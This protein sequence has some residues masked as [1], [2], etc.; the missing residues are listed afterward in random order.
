[1]RKVLITGSSGLVGSASARLFA[2]EEYAVTGIDNGMRRVFFGEE[3]ATDR[4]GAALKEELKDR[5]VQYAA[6]IRD[7]GAIE[8]VF[9][10]RG[11]F[12]VVIHAAAQ[13]S[14]DWAARDP[15]L[16]FDVNARATL[17]LL[18]TCRR[19]SPETVFIFVSTNKVYGDSMNALPFVEGDTRYDLSDAHPNF[20]GI[21]EGFGI[22][23]TLH[24]FLG[25][26][27]ASADL[28]VQEYGSTIGLMT[29]VFRA[30]CITG[31]AHQGAELHGFLAYLVKCIATGRMY[32][33][34]GYQGKQVRDQLHAHDVARMFLLFSQKPRRGEVYNVG[35]SRFANASVLESIRLAEAIL[36]KHALTEYV[37]E[38]RLGDHTWYISDISKFRSH[39]PDWDYT[40]TLEGILR[41]LCAVHSQ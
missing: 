22:D 1:M 5:F 39:Y 21:D 17:A 34:F 30:G 23:Q 36:G 38:P 24:T 11:P 27:K 37:S 35:G 28:I 12:D 7:T 3:A 31:A 15:L 10:E 6:D 13:P 2:G 9:E 4:I 20:K 41:E 26:S 19:L 18:E 32:R 25:V 40:Y 16:D 8:R 14:H 29:G 33:I